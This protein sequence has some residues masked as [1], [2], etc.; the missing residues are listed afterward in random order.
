MAIYSVVDGE[1]DVTSGFRPSNRPDHNG[2]DLAPVPRKTKPNIRCIS[3]G[4][5]ILIRYDSPTAGNYVEIIHNNSYVSRYVH[6]DSVNSK[7]QNNQSIS[8][9]DIIGKMG[10][11]GHCVPQGAVHLHFDIRTDKLQDL[12]KYA[13]DPIPY[14]IGDKTLDNLIS[15]NNIPVSQTTLQP[16]FAS[17]TVNYMFIP[18]NKVRVK[19]DAKTYA[20][21]NLASFVYDTTYE[22]AQIIG[23]RAIIGLRHAVTNQIDITAVMNIKDLIKI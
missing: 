2:V 5:I 1:V 3:D 13:I 7:L 6:L 8:K 16:S 4:K 10:A 12:N 11:T 18:G 22:I 19:Q 21:G 23:D 9:G 14:L 20:N 15:S 17:Y